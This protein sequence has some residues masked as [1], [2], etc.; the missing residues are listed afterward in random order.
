MGGPG[1]TMEADETYFGKDKSPKPT[2][3]R[4]WYATR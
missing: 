4:W 3:R 2:A 1:A